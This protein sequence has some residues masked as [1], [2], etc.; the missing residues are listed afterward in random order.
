M[1]GGGGSV[2]LIR[3]GERMLPTIGDAD[4]G[5]SGGSLEELLRGDTMDDECC[6]IGD[7]CIRPPRTPGGGR[8]CETGLVAVSCWW[9]DD[10]GPNE[11]DED[12]RAPPSSIALNELRRD[13]ALDP[14][15][16]EG[17]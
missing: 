10:M 14:G 15:A 13:C 6:R 3:T 1:F 4:D 12:G 8:W 16:V 17:P 7:V 2:W 5:L 9:F 11:C